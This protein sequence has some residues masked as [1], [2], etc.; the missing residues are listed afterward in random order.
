MKLDTVDEFNKI[1]S[2]L[3]VLQKSKTP[4]MVGQQAIAFGMYCEWLYETILKEKD[5]LDE[6]D[7]ESK[8]S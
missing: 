3:S 2:I 6:L 4:E 5:R 7:R 8:E 1:S